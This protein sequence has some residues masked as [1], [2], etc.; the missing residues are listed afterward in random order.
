MIYLTRRRKPIP[1]VSTGDKI[2]RPVNDFKKIL[3]IWA[4]WGLFVFAATPAE[5]I[6]VAVFNPEIIKYHLIFLVTSKVF[7][8]VFLKPDPSS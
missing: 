4:D 8:I 7:L 2:L 1:C 5:V 3:V 6:G